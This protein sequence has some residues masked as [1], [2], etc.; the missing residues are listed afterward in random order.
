MHKSR[1]GTVIIDCQTDDLEREA[2]FW[3]GAL[4]GRVFARDD[5]GR[6]LDITGD[7]S[8]PHVILQKVEHPSRIH[9]DIETDDIEAEVRRLEGLGGTVVEKWSAGPLWRLRVN[10]VFAS[11]VFAV[12]ASTKM[13][14]CGSNE[15]TLL[16]PGRP[17]DRETDKEGVLTA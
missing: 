10:I 11:S 8:D 4:G 6:Y 13:P 16:F 2:S 9:I 3:G 12:T 5:R 7:S 1:P 17:G 14:T 15:T